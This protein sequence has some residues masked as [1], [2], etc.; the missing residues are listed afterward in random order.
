MAGWSREEAEV[1]CCGLHPPG[2]FAMW[3]FGYT[4]DAC[5]DEDLPCLGQGLARR[6]PSFVAL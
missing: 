6:G 5:C 2:H 3:Y 4:K 1:F